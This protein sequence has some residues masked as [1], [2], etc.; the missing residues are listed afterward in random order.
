MF[1]VDCITPLILAYTHMRSSIGLQEEDVAR[2][3]ELE[4]QQEGCRA[5]PRVLVHYP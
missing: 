1:H 2:R 4:L 5:A 3:I